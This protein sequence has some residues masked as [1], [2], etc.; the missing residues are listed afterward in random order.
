[1][2]SA[3]K[4][5]FAEKDGVFAL[6]LVGDIRLTFGSAI[7]NVLDQICSCKK[8]SAVVIDLT[9]TLGIDST[10]LGMLAKISI[11]TQKQF[12]YMP[13]LVSCNEDITR[14]L[15]SM[16][17]DKVFI[18]IQE[19]PECCRNLA[20]IKFDHI[21]EPEIRNQVLEAHRV[22]MDLNE[23]NREMFRDLVGAL[24]EEEHHPDNKKAAGNI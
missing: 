1:M 11:R 17:M 2:M 24:Q 13:T 16:G 22:L 23:N 15:L 4:I 7:N 20:E 8:F 19:S 12:G 21:A 10:T 18:F 6:K 3:G 9:E 5:L 14:V